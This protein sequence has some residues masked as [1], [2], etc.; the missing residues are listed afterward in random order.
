MSGSFETG[1]SSIDLSGSPWNVTTTINV[2][3]QF[4]DGTVSLFRDAACTE[5]FSPP[6]LVVEPNQST[7][8]YFFI[9]PSSVTGT[10]VCDGLSGQPEPVSWIGGTHECPSTVTYGKILASRLAFSMSDLEHHAN[11][12]SYRFDI[13]LQL[14]DGR[15]VSV[16]PFI[17]ED[18][19]IIEK[20]EE[21]G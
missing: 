17:D 2:W 6:W 20:G 5:S 18:P 13:W 15:H 10:L 1:A 21:P 8:L 7:G 11:D 4:L 19:T 3:I 14:P 12:V 16:R 9:A